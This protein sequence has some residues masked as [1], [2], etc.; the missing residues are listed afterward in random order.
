MTR[1]I[2]RGVP[3]DRIERLVGTR[4]ILAREE[5]GTQLRDA[6]EFSTVL[7]ATARYERSEIGLAVCRGDR[8]EALETALEL[9][10]EHR[11]NL[12]KGI[13]WVVETGVRRESHVQWFHARSEIRDTIVGIVAGM[14]LGSDGI[15]THRPIVGFADKLEGDG[16]KVSARAPGRLA[17]RGIDLGQAMR[18]SATD[19][20]GDGGGHAMAAGATVPAGQEPAFLAAVDDVIGAQLDG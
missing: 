15:D 20:G 12:S 1:A 7:N 10:R 3:S 16:V 4:Y 9:L 2:E 13:E 8:E 5:P 14:V 6:S 17:N 18:V 11:T 19:V